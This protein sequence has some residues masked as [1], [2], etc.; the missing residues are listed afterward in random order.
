M[1]LISYAP[2]LQHIF[3]TAPLAP[4]DWVIV[5]AF[6]ALLFAAEEIRKAIVRSRR[7][8]GMPTGR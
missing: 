7:R 1:A 4:R 6:G 3:N 2:P 8:H 5:V